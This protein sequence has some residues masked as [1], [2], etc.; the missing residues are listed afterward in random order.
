MTRLALTVRQLWF[1][2][3]NSAILD[4]LAHVHR[5]GLFLRARALVRSGAFDEAAP[6]FGQAVDMDPTFD[7]AWEGWGEALDALGERV[8]ALEKYETAR[9]LRAGLRP[10]APDRHFVLRQ[11][12]TFT[13]EIVAYDAVVRSLAK[14][15]L[16]YLARGNAYLVTGQAEQALADYERALR[17]KPAV[18]EITALKGEALAMLGRHADALRAFD[19]ALAAR[20]NDAEILSGRAIVRI[21]MGLVEE[22]DADWRRQLQLLQGR[23]S[24]CACVALRM[25][26]Y[27]AALPHLEQALMKEP[28]DPYWL[29]YRLA[30]RRR[31]G[32][33]FDA[34]NIP[35]IDAWPGPLL[36][37]HAGRL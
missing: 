34:T 35:A 10:G 20:P 30:A 28:G 12:G 21:A 9:Q 1:R 18:P 6:L 15:T 3:R 36:A 16:P 13:A 33:P 24:A 4:D 31:Q 37:L 7:E 32:E 26:D 5:H 23:P 19:A 14:N 22:A 27:G 25:A 8:L 17:L 29:L 11:R 2:S